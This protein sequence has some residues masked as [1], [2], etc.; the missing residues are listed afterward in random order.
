MSNKEEY[1]IKKCHSIKLEEQL[2]KYLAQNPS[3]GMA[4]AHLPTV[5]KKPPKIHVLNQVIKH[6][7]LSLS[8]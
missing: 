6:P 1:Q 2:D 7:F 5:L 4:G 3:F 8:N